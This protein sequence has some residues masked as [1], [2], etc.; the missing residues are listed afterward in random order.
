MSS[1][2]DVPGSI[3]GND[4]IRTEIDDPGAP[5]VY[6]HVPFCRRICPYCDF[7]VTPLGGRG[8]EGAA[9]FAG[10]RRALLGEIGLRAARLGADTVYFGGGTPSLAPPGFFAEV[11]SALVGRG[12][13]APSPFVVIEANP[14]DLARGA[15]LGLARRLAGEGISGVSLG[16]QSLDDRRLRFLGR[17]HTGAE[18]RAAVSHLGEAGISW[19]SF[20]FLYGT[21]GQASAPLRG[22]L[23][24]AASLPGVTHLSAYELTVEPGT[25]FGRRAAAGERLCARGKGEDSLFRVVHETLAAFGFPAYEASNFASAPEQ[26]SRHNRKYWSGAG[27]LGIGPSAHSFAPDR[28]ERSWNHRSRGA[29]QAALER[30]V[31]PTAGHETLAP[32]ARALEELF[33][34]LRTTAGLDLD[35]FAARHGEAAVRANRDLFTGWETRGLVRIERTDGAARL[36]PTLSGLALADS[37][38]REV[39]L[40]PVRGAPERAAA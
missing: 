39:D 20:D 35:G 11:L 33:L 31:L 27:Y 25:A 13:A 26:Q 30:S 10:Y 24:A 29:W 34:Q 18:V 28:A 22:E 19:I 4:A 8:E 2:G 15:G 12:L 36:A 7:A 32:P 3:L 1:V 23:E 9:R 17:R 21:A 14:E 16:A 38:A 37:L 5:G 40:S 6:V